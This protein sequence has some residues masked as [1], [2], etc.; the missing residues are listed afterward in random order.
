MSS[1]LGA[2]PRRLRR[3]RRTRR[4]SRQLE[5]R[6]FDD[7]EQEV[8]H[9]LVGVAEKLAERRLLRTVVDLGGLRARRACGTER[10]ARRSRR[11]V[12]R[13]RGHG[14]SPSRRRRAPAR[15]CGARR[16]WGHRGLLLEH[17]EVELADRLVDQTAVV[18]RPRRARRHL[19]RGDQGEIGDFAPDLGERPPRVSA[20][21]CRRVLEPPLAIFL[22]SP[23]ARA[24][25]ASLRPGAPSPED[26]VR[27]APRLAEQRAVLLEQAARLVARVVG[28]FQ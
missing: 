18:F 28:L 16:L 26:L 10:A 25:A 21:I 12:R 9:E 22:P 8:P 20:S 1:T 17:A 27:L 15:R 19:L 24:R 23:G 5:A 13:P 7:D 2:C 6:P 3:A 4:C 14:S 11:A